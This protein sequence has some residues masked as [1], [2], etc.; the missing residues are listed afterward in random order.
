MKVK[1]ILVFIIFNS[2]CCCLLADFLR[3]MPCAGFGNKGHQTWYLGSNDVP[4][5]YNKYAPSSV[6]DDGLFV[7]IPNG[8]P[9]GGYSYFEIK[10]PRTG[11]RDGGPVYLHPRPGELP[12]DGYYKIA[13]SGPANCHGGPVI[14]PVAGSIRISRLFKLKTPELPNSSIIPIGSRFFFRVSGGGSFQMGEYFIQ[15]IPNKKVVVRSQAFP[16]EGYSIWFEP[17]EI[18]ERT[19]KLTKE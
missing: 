1:C 10:H 19:F 12:V 13:S 16:K 8:G 15:E 5:R 9:Y 17:S 14:T 7:A 3:S 4:L 18:V 11:L 6:V 2:P